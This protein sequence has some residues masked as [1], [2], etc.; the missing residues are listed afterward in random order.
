MKLKGKKTKT[1][2]EMYKETRAKSTPSTITP[3]PNQIHLKTF[4]AEFVIR[5]TKNIPA[6]DPNPGVDEHTGPMM[7]LLRKSTLTNDNLKVIIVMLI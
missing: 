6:G 4:S 5:A 7:G 2:K 3:T 1:Y